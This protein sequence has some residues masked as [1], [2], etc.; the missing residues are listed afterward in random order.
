MDL[1]NRSR[2]WRSE[3]EAYLLKRLGRQLSKYSSEHRD[4]WSSAS[5][6]VSADF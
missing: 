5:Y 6:E 4:Q 3:C 2:K 1:L